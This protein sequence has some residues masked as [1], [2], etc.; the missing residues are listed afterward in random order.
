MKFK[1]TKEQELFF[2]EVKNG[3]GNILIQAYAGCAKTTSA[4]ESLK[5]IEEGKSS[6]FLAFNKHIRDELKEKLPE[7]VR[8]NTLHSI[9]YGAILR[10]YKE[11]E[12][13]EFKIDKIIRRLSNRWK[14]EK[15]IKQ[16]KINEYYNELKKLVGLCKLTMTTNRKYIP[17]LCDRYSIKYSSNNDIRRVFQIL[18]E[19]VK[20]KKTIDF[21][22]MVFLPAYDKKIFLIPYDYIYV[23]EI[24][25]L[26]RA[27]QMMI[28][29]MVKKDR[30]TNN[31]IGRM[32]LIG[33]KYQTI[34]GFSG[35]SD[36][37]FEW[38][39]NLK[40]TKQMTLSTSFRCGK[41]IIKEAQ[42]Y[43]NGIQYH[44]NAIEGIVR[45]DGDVLN[46]AKDG[47]F[48]L[49]RT[50]L[51]LVK[52]FFQLLLK[53]KKAVIKGSDIG[54]SLKNMSEGFNNIPEMMNYWEDKLSSYK[55]ELL[56]SNVLK[57]SEDS[58]YVAL[59]DRVTTLNF[60]SKISKSIDDLNL[61]INNIFSDEVEGIM[62]ST[63]HKSKGLEAD[64]VFI[65]RSDLLPMKSAIKP[66]EKVQE[67][68]LIYVAITRAK[69]ELIYDDIWSDE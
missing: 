50:T 25:D 3:K 37:S 38:Y 34:Y 51:P 59:E 52:L 16:D 39:E 64:R 12:F 10:K 56:K 44:K 21:N 7:G 47:D 58:G 63:I 61:K 42:K 29:K 54:N 27:Q 46:E 48:V 69:K 36:K 33:D 43:T 26:N 65:V 20:D 24:Q 13:D 49:C 45:R 15:E 28:N 35:V 60:I 2:N 17:F 57:P 14:I 5:Y 62:L 32:I 68:N 55:R 6:I 9:G 41:N 18:E 30:K 31:I 67:N 19:S 23:D 8:T 66:W 4:I 11:V 1:P 53:N 22:D 40:N